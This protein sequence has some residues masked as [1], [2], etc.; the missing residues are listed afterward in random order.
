MAIIKDVREL[1]IYIKDEYIK[2]A[3][4]KNEIS[5]IKLQKA[6]YF[7]FAYWG[8]FVKSGK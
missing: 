3:K 8:G 1:A 4:G 5:P 7:C 2:F 6:L